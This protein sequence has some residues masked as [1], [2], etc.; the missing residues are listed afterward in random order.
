[1]TRILFPHD[2]GGNIEEH[3]PRNHL[4]L[5]AK[6]FQT[7]AGSVHASGEIFWKNTEIR[8]FTE[9]ADTYLHSAT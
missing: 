2:A 6:I 3:H 7:L 4:R 9:Q 8:N 1:L 5:A